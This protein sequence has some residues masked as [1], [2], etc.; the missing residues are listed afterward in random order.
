MFDHT[1]G[2]RIPVLSKAPKTI[3]FCGLLM[4]AYSCNSGNDRLRQKP[5][6]NKYQLFQEEQTATGSARLSKE[7]ATQQ[8]AVVL[9]AAEVIAIDS[10]DDRGGVQFLYQVNQAESMLKPDSATGISFPLRFITTE[11]LDFGAYKAK[12]VY[13]FLDTLAPKSVLRQSSK[14]KYRW[15]KKAPVLNG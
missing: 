2:S 7:Q 14:L 4:L 3:L 15:L 10:A 1:P 8:S 11:R 12:P 6:G 13:I 5:N 9:L